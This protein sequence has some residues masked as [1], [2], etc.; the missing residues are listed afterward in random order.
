MIIFILSA[1][2]VQVCFLCSNFHQISYDS[3]SETFTW[4]ACLFIECGVPPT[5][6]L[7]QYDWSRAPVFAFL[8]VSLI[9]LLLKVPGP[10]LS[11][12]GRR[13]TFYLSIWC[14]QMFSILWVDIIQEFWQSLCNY[15]VKYFFCPILLPLLWDSNYICGTDLPMFCYSTSSFLFSISYLDV[16]VGTLSIDLSSIE[17]SCD[18]IGQ[19][20]SLT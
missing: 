9:M 5:E 20:I 13:Y 8:T 10:T 4:R 3:S 12:I 2:A 19:I 6:F 15:I 14:S 18:P 7:I 17:W 16:E 11:R 1:S